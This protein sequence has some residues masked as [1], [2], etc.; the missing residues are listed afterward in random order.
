[1]FTGQSYILFW[2]MSICSFF[3]EIIMVFKI[4]V[5]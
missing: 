1:M 3:D 4:D 2:D 5:W